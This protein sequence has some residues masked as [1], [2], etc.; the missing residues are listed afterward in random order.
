MER[1]ELHYYI[2][3]FA[4]I[5]AYDAQAQWMKKVMIRAMTNAYFLCEC[6]GFFLDYGH[7]C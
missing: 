2:T 4:H 5:L 1:H 6:A 7:D 3:L